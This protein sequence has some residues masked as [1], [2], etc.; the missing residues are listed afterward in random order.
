MT[1]T[2][3]Q[4]GSQAGKS[5]SHP[6][7]WTKREQSELPV[8]VSGSLPSWLKGQLMR[9]AP[10]EFTRAGIRIE[11]WFDAHGLMYAFDFGQGVH[12]KQQLLG[13][14]ILAE[15]DRGQNAT[16]TFGT[17]MQRNLVQRLFAP[18]PRF[19]DNTNVNV[20]PW[21]GQWLAMTETPHQHVIDR[22]TLRSRGHYR[23]ADA[24]PRGL[25]MLAHPHY[26]A[27]QS[28]MVNVGSLFGPR[29]ELVVYRQGKG[30][31]Q[32][33]VE[34]KL[35]LKRLPYMHAFG[36]TPKSALLIDH[37]LR[38]S[39]TRMLFSNRG[40]IRHFDWQPSEGTRLWQLD[41]ASGKFRSYETEALFCF[42]T[43]NAYEDGADTVFDFL[44]YDD[45]RVIDA[46]YTD[47][48]AQGLPDLAPRLVRARLSPGK[49]SVQLE[50]LGEARF[51][52][53]QIAYRTHQGKRHRYVWG[54]ELLGDGALGLRSE[55][56]KVDVESGDVHRYVDPEFTFGEP[57][58]VPRPGATHEDDGVLLAVGSSPDQECSRLLVLDAATLEV[59][60][61]CDA[62]VL[63]PLGF[64]G[65]FAPAE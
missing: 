21:Q 50:R 61:K 51:E 36:L 30:S 64:H 46:L 45:A 40:F 48:L 37:P 25:S 38:A 32:R 2:T 10:A 7:R 9:T 62:D 59:L 13:S 41:R 56:V 31:N 20:V 23:Y 27:A 6:F 42:H 12:F 44:A 19:T 4:A 49:S 15:N 16:A 55:V 17:S 22:D 35:P 26:D 54:T 14:D 24:L 47:V 39:A 8:R 43:V 60:A 1:Q 11:H 65:T 3:H 29:S 57:V 33:E 5:L 63:I 52:F 34:G 58:C 53:P 18:V 28:A